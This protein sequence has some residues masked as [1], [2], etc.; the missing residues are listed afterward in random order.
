M[1]VAI[2]KEV[3]STK[4]DC[5]IC[6]NSRLEQ[7]IELEKF[8]FTGIF[9]QENEKIDQL[10]EEGVNQSF[11]YC[12]ECG[13]GQLGQIVDPRLVYNETY[14]HR[15]SRSPIATQGNEFFSNFVRQTF[16]GKAF[17]NILDVG[18]NDGYL[19]QALSDLGNDLC[20][21]D[22]IWIGKD[23]IFDK[24][25]R[26][27]GGFAEDINVQKLFGASPDLV[28]SAHTFE[29]IE[30]P[31]R[32]LENLLNQVQD[33]TC[34][35][36]E[37]PSLDTMAAN[38]RFDQVFHQHIQ[39]FS[40]AS[41]MQLIRELK[42]EYIAHAFNYKMWGGTMLFAFKKQRCKGENCCNKWAVDDLKENFSYF[43][44]LLRAV[45][46]SLDVLQHE[47]IYGFGAAQMLPCLAYH[48]P[49]RM[50]QI[51]YIIDDDQS[52]Q[53]KRYPGFNFSICSSNEV[54]Y[55]NATIMITALDSIR[56][57]VSRL[58]KLKAKRI[59]QPS[60]VY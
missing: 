44:S 49:N 53:G 50:E 45:S 54:D 1:P 8:P 17:K 22:P 25:I 41:M 6:G 38:Y 26:L 47:Q 51:T 23:C 24:K 59:L 12:A 4:T 48:M 30:H 27:S 31:K 42:C 34:F 40:L 11:V 16:P 36:I 58:T 20:G 18:C 21:V 56:P 52:R 32:V 43:S 37:V 57:I 13:H 39:Y 3:V 55:E 5:S 9:L 15:G 28:V 29:H 7:I 35:V 2:F 14:L 60:I 33:G 19:L 46:R 10:I